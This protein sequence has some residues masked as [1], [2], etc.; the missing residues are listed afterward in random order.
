MKSIVSEASSISKAIDKAWNDAG[1]P[2]EFSVNILEKPIKNFLGFTIRS[3][4]IALIFPEVIV[5]KSAT[6]PTAKQVSKPSQPVKNKFTP[7][8]KDNK[9]V[10]EEKNKD[11]KNIV[12]RATRP[13]TPQWSEPMIDNVKNWIQET[14]NTA[15]KNSAFTIEPNNYYLKIKFEEPVYEEQHRQKQLFASL[16]TLMLIMLKR[17]YKRPLRGY[18]IILTSDK[19][20]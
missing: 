15:N 5:K 12:E 20:A 2:K 9:P 1:K 10:E 13:K 11:P 16:A 6:R 19:D 4:K 8:A 3:A 7:K 18:K 14:L 17:Q